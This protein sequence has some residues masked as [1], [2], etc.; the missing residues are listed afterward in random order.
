MHKAMASQGKKSV[1]R[2]KFVGATETVASLC[3]LLFGRN[4]PDLILVDVPSKDFPNRWL[5]LPKDFLSCV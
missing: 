2:L 1:V 5:D 4:K 3:L